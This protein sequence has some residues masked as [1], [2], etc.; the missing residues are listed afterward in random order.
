[1]AGV[2]LQNHAPKFLY[3]RAPTFDDRGRERVFCYPCLACAQTTDRGHVSTVFSRYRWCV[4]MCDLPLS[5]A[6]GTFEPCISRSV[7]DPNVLWTR[8]GV[9]DSVVKKSEQN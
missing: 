9:G 5:L 8:S 7:A 1:M 6:G 2:A 3:R 4:G